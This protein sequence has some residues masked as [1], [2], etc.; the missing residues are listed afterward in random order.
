MGDNRIIWKKELIMQIVAISLLALAAFLFFSSDIVNKEYRYP[1]TKL[2]SGWTVITDKGKLDGDKLS[3]IKT[4]YMSIG[5][6][7]VM[8][9]TFGDDVDYYNMPAP[10]LYIKTLY[11]A[12]DVYFD[13]ELIYSFGDEY[14]NAGRLVEKKINYITIPDKF[15]GSNLKIVLRVSD[16]DAFYALGPVYLGNRQDL[17]RMFFNER[18]T[19]LFV[20]I[21]LMLFSIMQMI[22]IPLIY[23]KTRRNLS[24]HISMIVTLMLGIYIMGFYNL[25]SVIFE[26]PNLNVV[27][28]YFSL[29]MLPS[30]MTIY[31]TILTEGRIQTLYKAFVVFDILVFVGIF[32]LYA[33]N[34]ASLTKFLYFQHGLAMV[35]CIPFIVSVLREKEKKRSTYFD[36][37]DEAS[38]RSIAVGFLLYF[39]GGFADVFRFIVIRTL[40]GKEAAFNIPYTIFGSIIFAA[41]LC[42]HYILQ[43]VIRT[44]MENTKRTL[45]QKAY[46]DPL[47]GLANRIQYEQCLRELGTKKE[48]FAIVS[49]DIDN[50]KEVND[51]LGHSAGDSLLKNFAN[52]LMIV[53]GRCELVVRMG[54]DEFVIVITGKMADDT[55]KLIEE[56]RKEIDK[57]SEIEADF[58]YRVSFG[59]ASSED[60][61]Y[62]RRVFDVY[63]LA[64]KRMYDMKNK[65]KEERLI[66]Y[67]KK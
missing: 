39:A 5:D 2:D 60:I 21:F 54:G 67:E 3:E 41:S 35:Q 13:E 37:I 34:I 65:H 57:C 7:C 10:T 55:Q 63:M 50:L 43:A 24:L 19:P 31:F 46:C 20:G 29:Y 52:I 66:S 25:F 38:D 58:K 33:L 30:L 51:V 42:T 6:E 4:G 59:I 56:M 18:R 17:L 27:F 44:G 12:V 22:F 8:L 45:M 62:G 23:S 14:Y 48:K 11:S 64:D 15:R 47:T 61:D 53:F 16:D 40:T 49:I 32:T 28:E 9:Y 36:K 26:I 1:I